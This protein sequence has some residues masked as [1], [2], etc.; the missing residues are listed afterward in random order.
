[1]LVVGGGVIG[2]EFA[3]AYA[4]L[5]IPTHVVEML[6]H[7]LPGLDGDAGELARKLL[8]DRG[9]D[10]RTGRKVVAVSDYKAAVRVTLDDGQQI[11]VHR[12]LVAVGRVANIEDIGLEAVGLAPADGI[13]PVDD[14]CRTSVEGV[15]A[16]GDLAEKR[17]YAHLADRMGVVAA[18]NAMG[19]D[20]A[21]DRT[22]VPVGVYTHPEIASVG[23]SLDEAKQRSPQ[24]R[25][26]RA[27]YAHSGTALAYGETAGQLKVVADADSGH[28]HGAMWIGP[29]AIDM[30]QEFALAMRHGLTLG[31]V[32]Q[33]IHAHPTFQEAAASVAG[34]W[35]SQAMRRRT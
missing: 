27:A 9:A 3:T 22:V 33:T 30:I 11:E 31:Q 24:A 14:R 28:I 21:D 13:I 16:V 12:I 23:L 26:F 6:D 10:V 35:L 8:S 15:Y 18:D 19:F 25:V 1:V 20:L 34:S 2:C 17:Q 32:H 5:G 7:L 4:E 29:H